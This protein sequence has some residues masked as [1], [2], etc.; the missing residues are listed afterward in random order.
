MALK[1]LLAS[2]SLSPFHPILHEQIIR[3]QKSISTPLITES[4]AP[5]VL[6]IIKEQ[7]TLFPANTSLEAFNEKYAAEH[8][9]GAREVLAVLRVRKLLGSSEEKIAK[10]VGGILELESVSLEE[11]MEGLDVLKQWGSAEVGGYK[12]RAVKKWPNATVFAA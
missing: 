10:D 9:D 8:K 7:F 6:E 11:G 3:F 1:C 12:E 5:Q 2:A 4:I